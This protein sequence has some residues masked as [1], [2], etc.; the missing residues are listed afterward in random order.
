MRSLGGLT[1]SLLV[2]AGI[3]CTAND[4]AGQVAA[5]GDDL[6]QTL[7]A[8]T[9]RPETVRTESVPDD[10]G[11]S[12]SFSDDGRV[13]GN[14]GCNQ[15][16]GSYELTAGGLRLGPIGATRKLCMEPIMSRE[17]SFLQA[18]ELTRRVSAHAG[19]LE[20]LDEDGEVL[21]HLVTRPAAVQ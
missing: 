2:V 12:M 11:I 15:F 16:F 5:D 4:G 13:T 3:A 6:L 14:G 9:W 21:V 20:L 19:A 1:V 10:S 18:L 7:T 8:G 17:T